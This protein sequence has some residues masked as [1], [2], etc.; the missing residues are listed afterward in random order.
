VSLSSVRAG[1]VVVGTRIG[2]LVSLEAA[3]RVAAAVEGSPASDLQAGL[4]A[5][6]FAAGLGACEVSTPPAV[7]AGGP[8]EATPGAAEGAAEEAKGGDDDDDDDDG[9]DDGNTVAE[10]ALAAVR[11]ETGA[12]AYGVLKCLP[13]ERDRRTT[14]RRVF[15]LMVLRSSLSLSRRLWCRRSSKGAQRGGRGGGGRRRASLGARRRR[16][17]PPRGASPFSSLCVDDDD[18]ATAAVKDKHSLLI[19]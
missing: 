5:R 2:G 8:E 6:L 14:L 4:A 18:V 19:E 15:S 3:A 17:A 16:V 7:E 1:S 10:A 12:C 13:T 9:D 11:A